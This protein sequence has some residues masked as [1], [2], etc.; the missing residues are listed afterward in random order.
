MA[1][2][3]AGAPQEPH[4]LEA[5]FDRWD[6]AKDHDA[7]PEEEIFVPGQLRFSGIHLLGTFTVLLAALAAWFMVLTV[8]DFN[9]WL[10]GGDTPAEG[11]DLRER[12]RAGEKDLTLG[13]NTWV[14]LH[15]MFATYEHLPD[16]EALAAAERNGEH[17]PWYFIDPL[18]NVVVRTTQPLPDKPVYRNVE[19]DEVYVQLLQDRLA[20]PADLVIALE[21]TGRLVRLVDLS[22][23]KKRFAQVAAASGRD[24]RE[25]WVFEDGVAPAD[26]IGAAVLW[27]GGPLVPLASLLLL[28]G[29]R[30]RR[31]RRAKP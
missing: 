12:W 6:A 7:P 14:S 19:V 23:G 25:V 30:R 10:Q 24:P 27:F 28:L 21:G 18:F 22:T 17:L 26:K 16:D 31:R 20:Y 29:A 1:P 4:E 2:P 3:P 11:G 15:G 8:D 13:S 5:L 9:Y